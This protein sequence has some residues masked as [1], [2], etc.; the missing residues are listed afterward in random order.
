M[1]KAYRLIWSKAKDAWVIVAE[2]V[3]GNG[4]PPPLTVTAVMV[5]AGLALAAARADALPTGQQVVSGTAPITMIDSKTMQINNSRNAVINWQGFSIANGERTQFVQPDA[6]S[7]V[8]NR[9]IGSYKSDIF[10]MLDSNGRVFL[11]NPNGILFGAGSQVNVAGLVASSLGMSNSDFLNGIYRFSGSGQSGSVINQGTITTAAGGK[12]WLIAP[13]V[14]NSGI[15]NAPN[16]DVLL[17]AG[18][19]VHLVDPDNPEVAVVVSAP[20]DKALNIGTITAAA[21]KVGIFGGLVDQQGIVSAS[22]AVAGPGGRIY[23]KSTTGTTLAAGS[24]TSANASGSGDGGRVVVLSDGETKVA[25]SI[26]ARG[27]SL[28]GDGGFIETSGKTIDFSGATINASSSKGKSGLWLIDPND[29]DIDTAGAATISGTLNTGTSVEANTAG[30]ATFGTVNTSGSG[31]IIVSAAIGKTAGADTSLTLKADRSITVNAPITS[32]SGKLDVT[33]NAH[34]LDDAAA[35]SVSINNNITTN[36]G[37]FVAGGG[38]DPI[39][40]PAIGVNGG[41]GIHVGSASTINTGTGTITLTGT[42]G[43]GLADTNQPGGIGV[44]LDGALK[45]EGT[46]GNVT[47]SARVGTITI[48]GVGG[49]GGSFTTVTGDGGAGGTGVSVS[50]TGSVSTNFTVNGVISGSST[51]GTIFIDGKG[52]RGGDSLDGTTGGSGGVGVSSAGPLSTTV[53]VSTTSDVTGNSVTPLESVT[54]STVGTITIQG[55]IGDGSNSGGDGGN[56]DFSLSTGSMTGGSGGNGV[57]IIAAITSNVTVNGTAS[58]S[59]LGDITIKGYGGNGGKAWGGDFYSS[60]GGSAGSATGGSGGTGVLINAAVAS[61]NKLNI[62]GYGGS[63]GRAYGGYGYGTN[64]TSG[65]LATGGSGG[66]GVKIGSSGVVS[67]TGAIDIRGY[68]GDGGNALGG[69]SQNYQNGGKG[70]GGDGGTGI[71]HQGRIEASSYAATVYLAGHGGY[72]GRGEGGWGGDGASTGGNGGDG[73][74]GNGGHGIHLN[75]GAI[76]TGFGSLTLKGYGS[77]GGDGY[78]GYSGF[79]NTGG[80]RGGDGGSLTKS[81]GGHGIL[82]ENSATITSDGGNIYLRGRGR[83]GGDGYGGNAHGSSSFASFGGNGF[84][85][86]GGDG[87]NINGATI[88]SSYGDIRLK[89]NGG[90]GGYAHGGYG[91][92]KNGT[93]GDAKGGTGGAGIRSSAG[94]EITTNGWSIKLYGYGGDGGRGYGGDGGDYN[95]G[96]S[97]FGG[98][99]GTGVINSGTIGTSAASHDVY[100]RGNG[101]NGGYAWGGNGGFGRSDGTGGNGGLGLGGDGGD[102]F[103]GTSGS[104]ILTGSGNITIK[105]YGG[106]SGYS[107]GGTSGDGLGNGARGGNGG[108]FYDSSTHT[109]IHATGGHGI[110]L[111]SATVQSNGGGIIRLSG[112][113]G[114]GGNG[115][116]GN[117]YNT[118]YYNRYSHG[119]HGY[120][121][122]GGDGIRISNG[123]IST[124]GDVIIG[125]RGGNGGNGYGGKGYYDSS[126]GGNGI[127]GN[128]GVGVTINGPVSGGYISITGG[129]GGFSGSGGVGTGADAVNSFAFAGEGF[130]GDGGTGVI[131]SSNITSTG[132]INIY[133][134]GGNGGKGRDG[135][136][137]FYYAGMP[138]VGGD[139]GHGFRLNAG[140]ISAGGD[141]TIR[142]YGGDGGRAYGSD[143]PTS[144]NSNHIG[145]DA[146]GGRGGDGFYTKDGTIIESTGNNA[147]VKLY[148][149]GGNGGRAWGGYSYNHNGGYAWGGDGGAGIVH[150]GTIQAPHGSSVG[151][152]GYGGRGGHAYGGNSYNSWGGYA[153]GGKGGAGV[154]LGSTSSISS[155]TGRI[156]IEGYG[157]RGGYGYYGSPNDGGIGLGGDGGSGVIMDSASVSSGSGSIEIVGGFGPGGSG[158]G[159]YGSNGIGIDQRGAT[160]VSSSTGDI[161]FAADIMNLAGTIT[162]PTVNLTVGGYGS[163]TQSAGSIITAGGLELLSSYGGTISLNESNMVATLAANIDSISFVNGKALTVGTVNSTTGITATGNVTLNAPGVTQNA[164]AIITAAGLELLGG[165]FTLNEANMVNTLAANAT[166]VSF[167]NGTALNIGTVNGTTGITASG[168]VSLNATDVTQ[169]TGAIITAAGLEL[170]GGTFTL[171]EANMVDT[172]AA[173]AASV[174]FTNGK[175]LTVGTV[176]STGISAS[177]SVSLNADSMDITE[178]ITAPTVSLGRATSGDITLVTSTKP[179]TGG[180]E[181]LD[182]ELG[183]ITASNLNIGNSNTTA[184]TQGGV[185]LTAFTDSVSLTADAM[186]LDAAITATTVSLGRASTGAIGLSLDVDGSKPGNVGV[187]ELLDTELGRITTSNLNIGNDKTNSFTQGGVALTAP[188]SISLTADAMTLDA[189]ITATTVSLGRAT[190][191]DITLGGNFT[192]ISYIATDNLNIGNSNTASFTQGWVALTAPTSISLTADAMTLNAMITAPTVS[193]TRAT[194]GIINLGIDFTGISDVDATNLNIGDTSKT[195]G[196]EISGPID[197]SSTSTNL[198][199]TTSGAVTFY[200]SLSVGTNILTL[201]T[202]ADSSSTQ[203]ATDAII[204]ASGLKLQG[205]TFTLNEANMVDTLA[206]NAASV[207]FTNG[208]LLTV[209]TVNGTIGITASDS[210]SLNADNMTIGAKVDAPIVSLGRATYG[211]ITLGG[212]FTGISYVAT[213]N[214]NIGNSNTASFTQGG[215][216]LD[217]TTFVLQAPTSI[218]LTADAMTLDAAISA[219]TV[220]LGR[221]TSGD[222]TLGGNLAG[223][224]NVAADNLN[225]GNGNTTSFMQGGVA[226]T[227]PT[228]TISLTADAMTLDAAIS[229]T[230]V[231]LNSGTATQSAGSVITASGLELLGGDFTLNQT[232]MVDTLAANAA[233]VS[234]TNGKALNIGT[235]NG[236]TGITAGNVILDVGTYSATQDTGAIITAAGLELLGGTFTL[237]QTNMVDTLAANATSVSFTNGTALNIGTVNGS[238]GITASGNVTLNATGVTQDAGAI[239]TAAGLELLGGTFTL[240]EAN[241]VDTLAANAGYVA[242]T[243]GKALTIGTV[244]GT[245]GITA[246]SGDGDVILNA[247]SVSQNSGAIISAGGLKLGDGVF[248]LD[249]T[250][251]VGTLSANAT[252]VS[253]TNGKALNIGTTGSVTGITATGDVTLNATAVTQDYYATIS[254]AGLKLQGGT[255]TLNGWN[256]VDTLAA[257]NATS[258]SFTNG[259]ALNIGTVNGTAGITATGDVNLYATSITQDAGAIITAAGLELLGGTFTLNAANMVNTLAADATSVT[260]TNSK[261]LTI[262]T[263]NGTTGITANGDVTL[264]ATGGADQS[265]LIVNAPITSGIGNISLT[266]IG[267]NSSS[268]AGGIGVDLNA[269]VSSGAAVGTVTTSNIGTISINGTGGTGVTTGGAG[270]DLRTSSITTAFRIAGDVDSTSKIGNVTI[271]GTGGS[272]P[273]GGIGI[274]GTPQIATEVI[275]QINFDGI[276]GTTISSTGNI[277]AGAESGNIL[278]TGTGGTGGKGID[279][280]NGNITATQGTVTLVGAGGIDITNTSNLF[281]SNVSLNTS[282]GAVNYTNTTAYALDAAIDTTGGGTVTSGGAVTISA[283]AFSIGTGSINAGAADVTLVPTVAGTLIGVEDASRPFNV[284]LNPITTTGTIVVGNAAAG[285][286]SVGV[287]RTITRPTT[288][289]SLVSGSS[290]TTGANDFTV[291]NLTTNSAGLTF[292]SGAT[293]VAGNLNTTSTGAVAQSGVI[294]VTGTSNINAGA[295]SVALN[296]GAN[297]FVGALTVT[298]GN[299][300]IKD[301]N[302]LT[303]HLTSGATDLTSAGALTLDGTTGSLTT[304]STGLTFGTTTVTGDLGSTATG[305]V[306]QTGVVTVTGTSSINAGANSVTL[307]NGAND[308]QGALTVTGGATSIKDANTLTAHLTTSATDLTTVGALT[309]DGTSGNLTANSAGLTFG[310]GATT[311]TGNLYATSTGAV[312]Q[313]GILTVTGAT[314]INAGT[315]AVT[316][317]DATNDFGGAV[318]V[319]GG[320]TGIKDAN[321]LTAH[322]MTG[323][324]DLTTV[325]A[326][327][328]D[329]TSGTLTTNSAGL[330][331]GT[332][333]TSVTGSLNSTSS[334]DIVYHNKVSSTTDLT[335]TASGSISGTAGV[336]AA[337]GKLSLLAGSGITSA[338]NLTGSGG[339]TLDSGAGILDTTAGVVSNSGTAAAIVFKTGNMMDLGAVNSGTG[340]VYVTNSTPGQDIFIGSGASIAALAGSSLVFGD[341]TFTGSITID[342]PLS[343]AIPASFLSGGGSF[344]FLNPVTSTAGVT[345]NT[346]NNGSTT[347]SVSGTAAITAPTLTV[348]AGSGINLSGANNVG[349]ASLNNSTSGNILFNNSVTG[350]LTVSGNNSAAGGSFTVNESTG[351]LSVAGVTTSNGAVYLTGAGN[352]SFTAAVTAGTGAVSITSSGGEISGLVD[353][354]TIS[355]GSAQLSAL[356]GIGVTTA[357]KT[358]VGQI[359]ASNT[360]NAIQLLNNDIT[361]RA[362]LTVTGITNG[363]SILLDNY[364]GTTFTGPVQS[365]GGTIT[366]ATHSPMTI[367]S[368]V[369]VTGSGNVSLSAG[370]S[371]MPDDN[372]LIYGNITSLFGDIALTAGGTVTV[373]GSLSAPN[374]KIVIRENMNINSA[375]AANLPEV[376][377]ANNSVIDGMGKESSNMEDDEKEKEKEELS[378]EGGQNGT[379]FKSLPNCN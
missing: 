105:G 316:L 95:N 117:G 232:N 112:N 265:G 91:Y 181:L 33:L 86:T 241:M 6:A 133:A 282:G 35:G 253:F 113:G 205:G 8:L 162:A 71:F 3:R 175:L 224:D 376:V 146:H 315:N 173:N 278:L 377:L 154:T 98:K 43:S 169:D 89:G 53:S 72:G 141:V 334:G 21:G 93:G 330:I 144:F 148:G 236:T 56:A 250:N 203:Q 288:S 97:G 201:K 363:G 211:D 174:S 359:G 139:G 64:G 123:N 281:A 319:T 24:V 167:T 118:N 333:A 360:N 370:P 168:N 204:T 88:R 87:V 67:G 195:S 366:L 166:S 346:L 57:E 193:L 10:G 111:D 348:S 273:N 202:G 237:N 137:G 350:G 242:F 364:G 73:Y 171:N 158:Q 103:N 108:G 312:D 301:A 78:G 130:G 276:T 156:S 244:N 1:N 339:V 336:L 249:Q 13:Q 26:S 259:K 161:T 61:S 129:E 106:T 16:G 96:A 294:T 12:V 157:G 216:K 116:G 343:L 375:K 320:T 332:G 212:N 150:N 219:T 165:T 369:N 230:T 309:V 94:S 227:A 367:G 239:I 246:A 254:A 22:A 235:V 354:P 306:G 99:G 292:G 290:I 226:L 263:V 340:S 305:A 131:I 104:S 252:S 342:S 18:N 286:I 119:G 310:G 185:A 368:G 257:A 338:G 37:N 19:S 248:A 153:W 179:G 49:D 70:I 300:S 59:T 349:T 374:G 270:V 266:G 84:G 83:G 243:N 176:N 345:I 74:G 255:V 269:A 327:T 36:G 44:L 114:N 233:S 361:K 335:M 68:G 77:Y 245:S 209:G 302:T 228:S 260:L 20:A 178:A 317:L 221:A 308:F 222:I 66:T 164:G 121:G 331:F 152:F 134:Y 218:S 102:G 289:I 82:L 40:T 214:L 58:G 160:V 277:M 5:M 4:G 280:L 110:V 172:L 231:N 140:T 136:G 79:G 27:G 115:Y 220:S 307:N 47:N 38:A 223:I 285:A 188:T 321:T 9:V 271:T 206:A 135:N 125:G 182:T 295:N 39:N 283:P 25:G 145:G 356:N 329:G 14:E 28:G 76:T 122:F 299:T 184:F 54:N 132:H 126:H 159:D 275:Q 186:T 127:G 50:A 155:S 60:S 234:F 46:V 180:L 304:T 15:I 344:N 325:G 80:G 313:T 194:S 322:L 272:G 23:L 274:Q 147:S 63:G 192:G 303:A 101:G 128:G 365:S 311:V 124:S 217:S 337:S 287:D 372:L 142:G 213:D 190:Y 85:G 32:T 264:A 256:M 45:T 30:A 225:I 120:G 31:D 92:G 362:D 100:I 90:N 373:K 238:T 323:T 347:G 268:G 378:I 284:A 341:V 296:N 151:L 247:T 291:N 55:N 352:V 279:L 267:G 298:G 177:N 355:A 41:A 107:Y 187:L 262:G 191:G 318:T 293:T 358:K 11:L 371:N 189:A 261:S 7:A 34:Y 240:N 2:I 69:D 149:Y 314:T 138:A 326:L 29:L 207:S 198:A 109:F 75:G 81:T 229:A 210:I 200:S 48:N 297:D 324:T 17:T 163:A 51:L 258:V 208:T 357:F 379:E 62:N 65:G 170:L 351:T 199:L 183:R 215:V 52:G 196:I 251:M 143:T 328:L 197:T 42:G 353:L